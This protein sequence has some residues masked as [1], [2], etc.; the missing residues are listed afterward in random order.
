MS[1][2][3]GATSMHYQHALDYLAYAYLQKSLDTE[4]LEIVHKAAALEPPFHE[5]NRSA[6]AHAF[7]AIPA[8]C[9]VERQ[10]WGAAAALQPRVPVAFPWQDVHV[11]FVAM[12]HFARALGMA[13][14]GRF[15]DAMAEVLIL[16]DI[17]T[18]VSGRSSYWGK[19]V[20][21]QHLSALAWTM[22]LSCWSL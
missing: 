2:A 14:E 4:A 1:E 8:R 3:L 20:E 16:K 9:A 7:A 17:E 18:K 5:V 21:I 15:E 12:T 11:E 6:A 13:H 19:Q 22:F 10:D